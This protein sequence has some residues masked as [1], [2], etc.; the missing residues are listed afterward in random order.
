MPAICRLSF[1][2]ILMS[3]Q[4]SATTCKAHDFYYSIKIRQMPGIKDTI[5][6][7]TKLFCSCTKIRDGFFMKL[8]CILKKLDFV[9]LGSHTLGYSI[10]AS[11]YFCFVPCKQPSVERR[12]YSFLDV[13]L[14]NEKNFLLRL[15]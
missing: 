7:E 4:T 13:S 2:R 5:F 8:N 15:T 14:C 10:S 3:Q 1:F 11:R 12:F 6:S 9:T